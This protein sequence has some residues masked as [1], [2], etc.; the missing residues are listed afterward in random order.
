MVQNCEEKFSEVA[1]SPNFRFIGNT[2]VGHELRLVEL[3]KHYNAVVFAYGASRDRK[4]GIPGENLRGVYSARDFVG[5]YNGYP[6]T[7]DL[8]P[9]LTSTE[10]AVV[11]GQGNVALD[12]ARILLTHVDKLKETDITENALA[13]LANSR[14]KRVHVVGRRGPMQAAFTIKEVRELM[15]IPDVFFERIK[16]GYF[17]PIPTKDLPRTQR[18]MVDLLKRG[19]Q[20][21]D[22]VKTWSLDFL[23]SPIAFES[24]VSNIKEL[25]GKT[26]LSSIRFDLNELEGRDIHSSDARAVSTKSE[27]S[28][29]TGLAFRSIG[30]KSTALP[31]MQQV[32]VHF[33]EGRGVITN[34]GFG[35]V[36][37]PQ[38]QSLRQ[39]PIP[40]MYC[41]GWVKRGP[42]GVI[43]NT[44]EDA[45]S[46]AE[47]II[48]DWASKRPFLDGG[49]GWTSIK[50]EIKFLGA[51]STDWK[52]WL[53]IDK[54]ERD[55]GKQAGKPR[56]KYV[57]VGHMLKLL[58]ED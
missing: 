16:D 48:A 53:K 5:W 41:S 7:V 23:M 38:T 57:N 37:A 51:M 4:L 45:F 22:A 9:D 31:G 56:V 34:D 50:E 52:D 2:E 12:V 14:I 10:T 33:D 55:R 6:E 36:V 24:T 21:P 17:P 30:Y 29:D 39:R 18:R 32:G 46:T 54:A 19:S 3:A 49:N 20:S 58:K 11:I 28:I 43:A 13:T 42:A 1:A 40:G 47:A 8:K 44:M 27:C 15:N 25:K 26:Q 35:R